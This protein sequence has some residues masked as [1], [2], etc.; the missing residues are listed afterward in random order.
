MIIHEHER[1]VPSRLRHA[2]SFGRHNGKLGSR[3]LT[4]MLNG[5]VTC[6][7]VG[8]LAASLTR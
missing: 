1:V 2:K 7:R 3:A 6:V 5:G 8:S 4:G